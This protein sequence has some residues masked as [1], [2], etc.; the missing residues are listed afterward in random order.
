M[1][2]AWK[3]VEVDIPG[4]AQLPHS[5]LG[6]VISA[7]DPAF[8][9]IEVVAEGDVRGERTLVGRHIEPGPIA[10]SL[11]GGLG[12]RCGRED[13]ILLRLGQG[14]EGMPVAIQR[15]AIYGGERV[16]ESLLVLRDINTQ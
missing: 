6:R 1:L 3:A 7:A 15:F 2:A 12:R 8:Q 13:L 11:T 10:L 5:N 4:P 16:I 9:V 14:L